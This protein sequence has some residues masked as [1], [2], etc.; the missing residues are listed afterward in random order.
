MGRS[1]SYPSGAVVAFAD[2]DC[3]DELDFEFLVEGFAESCKRNWPS[4]EDCDT[5]IG[6][7]DRAVAENCHAYV[8]VSEYCGCV[9]FWLLPKEDGYCEDGLHQR[10]VDQIAG[11]FV[12]EFA[13]LN[14]VGVMSNG[15]SVYERR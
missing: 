5:W 11:R 13:T 3:E 1:V 7:E 8:G 10:W 12:E 15:V 9:A 14:R 2:H 4:L 6:R